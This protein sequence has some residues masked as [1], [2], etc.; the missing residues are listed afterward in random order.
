M[1]R[2]RTR[3]VVA[4]IAAG[5]AACTGLGCG[6]DEVD[7]DVIARAAKA[8]AERG[9]METRF[10]AVTTVAN[11]PSLTMRMTATGSEDPARRIADHRVDMGSYAAA[12]EENNDGPADFRGRMIRI[13]PV[14]Y[15]SFPF[16][17]KGL[18]RPAR[19]DGSWFELDLR[20][21]APSAQSGFGN[22]VNS[23]QQSPGQLFD[24]I[25]VATTTERLGEERIGGVATTH[26]RGEFEFDR[27]PEAV[28][29]EER[30][31]VQSGA[32][33]LEQT[34][35]EQA[36]PVDVWIDGKGLVRRIRVRYEFEK[37][38]DGRQFDGGADMTADLSGFGTRVAPKP[39][40]P[41]EVIT[42]EDLFR[43]AAE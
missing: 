11:A 13:G 31:A 40:P 22:V 39:P 4:A 26:W 38:V 28:P 9:G 32:R 29:A 19:L 1:G 3:G 10:K 23:T 33:V 14:F 7:S 36:A 17:T 37:A 6:G 12:I 41:G 43:A 42:L 18:A 25:T 8:T 15:M 24:Y 2:G 35:G 21:P 5:L 16:M 30:R 20:K 34:T 27:L